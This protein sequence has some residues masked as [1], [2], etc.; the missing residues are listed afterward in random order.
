MR[1]VV[2]A[3][4][5]RGTVD[6][7][8]IL[9]GQHRGLAR[10]FDFLRPGSI[11]RLS[12]NP[13]EQSAGELRDAV[14]SALCPRLDRRRHDLVLVQGDT[15]SADGGALAARDCGIPLGHIEAGLRSF[16]F[17]QPWPEESYRVAIDAMADLL[18][19]PSEAAACNLARDRSIRGSVHLTGNS[20]IDALLEARG[21][22]EVPPRPRG[23]RKL[24]LLTC[25]RRE[26]RGEPLRRVAAACRRLVEVLPVRIMVTLHP[27]PLMRAAQVKL[28]GGMPSLRLVEPLR[29]EA[30]V[31]AMEASWLVL[32]DSGGLQEEAPA[33]GR[34]LLV[35]REVTERPEVLATGNAALV[36]T[37]PERI[38]AAVAALHADPEHYARMAEP[39][40]PYG[41]GDAG[42]R[43]AAIVEDYL[44]RPAAE[45][46][47]TALS[48]PADP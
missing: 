3:L 25:H 26:N 12:I 36:G 42:Q 24:I 43:I 33:L 44:A 23:A 34:P 38:V 8:V 13:A 19:A 17:L 46:G 48:C 47:H 7:K 11:G 21:K 1:P 40:F 9:T 10:F 6:Q 14:H 15:S 4:H 27:S 35:L 30:M 39:A 16:D 41:R 32:T 31:A 28:F 2:R 20:G 18:F 29:Y 5:D 45:R 22:L 37:D